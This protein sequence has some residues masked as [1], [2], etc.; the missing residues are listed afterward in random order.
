MCGTLVPEGNG[1]KLIVNPDAGLV[2]AR[3]MTSELRSV[4]SYLRTGVRKIIGIG[5]DVVARRR[6]GTIFPMRLS[7]GEA[8]VGGRT[9]FTAI[10]HDMTEL[11]KAR[12]KLLQS[13]RLAAIGEMLAGLSHESRNAL[14]QMEGCLDALQ[15]EVSSH[16]AQDLVARLRRAQRQLRQLYDDLRAFAAPVRLRL[17]VCE[18]DR[19]WRSSWADLGG[20]R[21]LPLPQLVV[22]S[23]CADLRCEV[24]P[25]A[26]GQVFRNVLDNAIGFSPPGGTVT[27]RCATAEVDGRPAVAVAVRDRGP[28]FAAGYEARV[29]EPFYTTR[30]EGT[31][32]GLAIVRRIIDAHGG[33]A[34]ARNADGGGAEVVLVLP[35]AQSR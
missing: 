13:E 26:I 11:E 10:L 9:T 32:L 7:V 2:V 28:G 8:K 17:Q 30:S 3:A 27:I 29:F 6:D 20:G 16:Q 34:E 25:F 15:G 4:E 31:G 22:E 1:R 23:P 24:D 35:R 14:Q 21:K 5:R 33:R 12:E 18:L 19:L